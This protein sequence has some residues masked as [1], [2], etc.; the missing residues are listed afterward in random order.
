MRELA[1]AD[2]LFIFLIDQNELEIL[3]I[4]AWRF[5]IPDMEEYGDNNTRVKLEAV[6]LFDNNSYKKLRTIPIDHAVRLGTSEHPSICL[7]LDRDVLLVRVRT[8]SKT[9]TLIWRLLG[10]D[11]GGKQDTQEQ[12]P[13]RSNET[14]EWRSITSSRDR[15]PPQND[16]IAERRRLNNS[17]SDSPPAAATA[18][19]TM[20]TRFRTR[21]SL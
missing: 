8:T 7:E 16:G 2:Q 17:T 11:G 4:L 5:I 21:S 14:E 3:A 1:E 18:V 6:T 13:R 19:T 12:Q 15:R 9:R 20:R 10:K